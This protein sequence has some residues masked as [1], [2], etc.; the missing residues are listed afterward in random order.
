MNLIVLDSAIL[1]N[2]KM[3]SKKVL[4]KVLNNPESRFKSSSFSM[5]KRHLARILG[6]RLNSNKRLFAKV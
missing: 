3:F 4:V 5:F 6:F 2:S 1:L